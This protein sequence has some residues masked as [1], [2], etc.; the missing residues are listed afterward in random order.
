MQSI[1]YNASVN[2]SSAHAPPGQSPG[3]S[4]FLEKMGEFPGMGTHELSKC[5]GVGTNKGGKCPAPE[6]VAFQHL[7]IFCCYDNLIL[8]GEFLVR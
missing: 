4:I 2:S 1:V 7:Y 3:I 8:S 5:P 6:I